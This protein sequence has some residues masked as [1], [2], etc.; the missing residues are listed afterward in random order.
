MSSL[1]GAEVLSSSE[2]TLRRRGSPLSKFEGRSAV[3]RGA[4]SSL[5][6]GARLRLF[7]AYTCQHKNLATHCI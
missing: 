3:S 2:D 4:L 5:Q 6:R 7:D 1:G